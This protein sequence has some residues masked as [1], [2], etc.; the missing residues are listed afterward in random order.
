[1]SRYAKLTITILL[2]WFTFALTASA[3]HLFLNEAQRVGLSVAFA[4]G[5][6]VIVFALWFALSKGFREFTLSL[7]PRV[8]TFTQIWRLLG[9]EFVVLESRSLLPAVFARS[10]GYGDIF[11]VR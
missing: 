10:A 5:T 11:I 1:M 6:P 2:A 8:I 3:K 7:N 9:I 4:A